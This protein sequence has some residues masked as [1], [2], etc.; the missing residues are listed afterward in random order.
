MFVFWDAFK[1][2]NVNLKATYTIADMISREQRRS[3]RPISTAR[4]RS[5]PS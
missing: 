4:G 3:T 5:M 2:Q 1:T